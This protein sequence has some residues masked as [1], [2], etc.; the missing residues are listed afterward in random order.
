[1]NRV[2]IKQRAK[3]QISGKIGKFFLLYLAYFVMIILLATVGTLIP[4][5]G[6]TLAEL[7]VYPMAFSILMVYIAVADGG[8]FKVADM[9]N[10]FYDWWGAIKTYFFVGIFT[11]LWSLLLIVPGI[12]KSYSYRLA[13]YIKAENK[14]MP[15]LEAIR[16]SKEIMEGHK[17]EWFVLDLS[18]LGWALLIAVTFGIAAIWVEPYCGTTYANAYRELCPKVIEAE[19]LEEAPDEITEE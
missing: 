15:A 13:L 3:T 16:R 2:E 1:M 9:F 12:I 7:V 4:Y 14:D 11:F 5:V 17:L 8:D 6:T 10:G 19:V 18:F